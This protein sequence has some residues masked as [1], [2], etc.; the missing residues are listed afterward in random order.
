MGEFG[1]KFR[2]A[3]ESKELSFDDVSNVIKITP[4]MLRAIEEEHFDQLP[5]GVFNKGFIRSYAKQLGLDP[6]DAVTEYLDQMRQ[7]QIQAQAAWQPVP[8][9]QNQASAPEKRSATKQ[10]ASARTPSSTTTQTSAGIDE[11]PHLQLPRAEHVRSGKKEYL[12]RASAEIPWKLVAVGIV[13]VIL[14]SVLWIRHS[15]RSHSQVPN[16][17]AASQ[18][19]ASA[20]ASAAA[21]S[22]SPSAPGTGNPNSGTPKPAPPQSAAATT[23]ASN[24]DEEKGD[25]TVRNFGKP[26]PTPADKS[27][28]KSSGTLML[29]IR[30]SENSWISVIADGQPLTEETLIAPANTTFRASHDF[31]V[32]VGNAAAVTFLWNGQELPA[33]GGEGE[34][35]T[36]V[37]DSNGMRLASPS[38]PSPNP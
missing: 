30:A 15:H 35:K 13:V 28:G 2:K 12:E 10:A 24:T 37:F 16:P 7:A 19:Q 9:A 36:L 31:V 3:R 21:S 1:D 33:Q 5:G 25:V 6:E 26:L 38:Q 22:G 27:S 4:R 8:P 18:P 32:K 20:P 23:S 29:T 34:V 17:T 11:L 14:G